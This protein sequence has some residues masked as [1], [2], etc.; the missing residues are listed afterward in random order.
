MSGD[1]Q[2]ANNCYS[3]LGTSYGEITIIESSGVVNRAAEA[4]NHGKLKGKSESEVIV[5]SHLMG[6]L[7]SR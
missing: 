4:M 7:T 1:S 3:K 5:G 6:G 2:T